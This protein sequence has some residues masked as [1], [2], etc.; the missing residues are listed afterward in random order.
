MLVWGDDSFLPGSGAIAFSEGGADIPAAT[1][2][3]LFIWFW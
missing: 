1:L 2:A 3:I